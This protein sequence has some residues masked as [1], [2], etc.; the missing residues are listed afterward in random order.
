M[1]DQDIIGDTHK[2]AAQVFDAITDKRRRSGGSCQIEV[3]HVVGDRM[4]QERR[5]LHLCQG[6]VGLGPAGNQRGFGVA[7]CSGHIAS[8]KQ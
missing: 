2:R 6:Q 7:L 1:D 3:A 4:G 8:G 5:E